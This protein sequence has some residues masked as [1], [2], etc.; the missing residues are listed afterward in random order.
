MTHTYVYWLIAVLIFKNSTMFYFLLIKCILFFLNT[1]TKKMLDKC[2]VKFSLLL[3]K[4]CAVFR[5]WNVSKTFRLFRSK[6]KIKEDYLYSYFTVYVVSIFFTNYTYM[7]IYSQLCA[8]LNINKTIIKTS[9][10][11]KNANIN[12]VGSNFVSLQFIS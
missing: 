1:K 2:Q 6:I 8:N 4:N 7:C 11:I 9:M 12:M 10:S 5:K 3:L